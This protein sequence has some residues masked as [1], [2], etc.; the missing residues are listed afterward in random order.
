MRIAYLMSAGLLPGAPGRGADGREHD[1]QLAALQQAGR[2]HGVDFAPVVWNAP[3]TP[4][5]DH[6]AALV[7]TAWDYAQNREAFFETLAH[8][9]ARLPLFNPLAL[10]RWNAD[11]GYLRALA[12]KG[13]PSIP[14]VWAERAD[15]AAISR[16]FETLGADDLVIKPRV[17][18]GAWRQARLHRGA[19]LPAPD[20]LP[21]GPC[22]M[23]PF[24]P[25]LPRY[26]EVSLLY[27]DGRYSHAARKIPRPGD[28]RVQSSYGAHEISHSPDARERACARAVMA[29]LPQMPF[30]ARIDLVRDAQDRPVVMEVELIEPYH[31]PEQG[32]QFAS[33]LVQGLLSRLQGRSQV[34]RS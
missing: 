16:A 4:W 25:S 15:A 29:A 10:M 7:G 34:P 23:Q 17:G 11:K 6:D 18:A 33:M 3:G 20:A 19:P 9:D 21:P 22:L 8:L 2:V 27:Y 28:Y 5:Q 26:G 12:Q 1:L 30:Y 14:A 31:Y 32:P 13:V 24:L